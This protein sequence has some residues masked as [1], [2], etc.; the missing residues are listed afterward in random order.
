VPE[1]HCPKCIARRQPGAGACPHCGLVFAN[2]VAAEH[3]PSQALA[4]AW[5]GLLGRWEDWEA[6]QELL[7]LALERGELAAAGRLYLLRLARAP[8]DVNAQR[9]REEVLRR[10]FVSAGVLEHAR[11]APAERE[12]RTP[13]WVVALLLVALVA[14][15]GFF[16]QQLQAS[17]ALP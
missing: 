1:G 11:A 6:H 10:A 12:R 2:F 9:G 8:G 14:A 3:Q 13:R 7:A 5:T 15:A 4:A 16:L 17:L